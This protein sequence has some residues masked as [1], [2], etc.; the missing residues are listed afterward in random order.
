MRKKLDMATLMQQLETKLR[1]ISVLVP[2][3]RAFP[4]CCIRCWRNYRI[5]LIFRI[6][7]RDPEK[8][9]ELI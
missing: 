5:A 1:E 7:N 2:S 6:R 8:L 3:P 4:V 9:Q